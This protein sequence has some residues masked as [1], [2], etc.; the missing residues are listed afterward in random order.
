MVREKGQKHV[1]KVTVYGPEEDEEDEED[2]EYEEDHFHVVEFLAACKG[3][4]G[5]L[6]ENVIDFMCHFVIIKG[7]Q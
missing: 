5:L 4:P 3:E 7:L 1:T 6:L 2:E